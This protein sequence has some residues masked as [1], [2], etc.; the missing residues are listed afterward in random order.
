[1]ACFRRILL[2]ILS[3]SACAMPLYYSPRTFEEK[4]QTYI[5]F[6]LPDICS[7]EVASA[8]DACRKKKRLDR[9]YFVVI[10]WH[11]GTDLAGRD[12]WQWIPAPTYWMDRY[13]SGLGYDWQLRAA[14]HTKML[15]N[16]TYRVPIH[17]GEGKYRIQIIPNTHPEME[18][19]QEFSVNVR[20]GESVTIAFNQEF[21]QFTHTVEP[22]P[23]TE[24]ECVFSM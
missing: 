3:L 1:M 22:T 21:T 6:H 23:P 4:E 2:I 8:A 9:S 15:D 12:T 19:K 18:I 10:D 13:Y 7:L 11:Y 5:R 17:S 14:P 20:L 24:V 16:C